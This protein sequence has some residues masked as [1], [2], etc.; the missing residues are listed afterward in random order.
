MLTATLS[1]SDYPF[2]CISCRDLSWVKIYNVDQRYE[3]NRIDGHLQARLVY[4]LMNIHT[5]PRC[6][7][8]CRHG[9]SVC[10]LYGR[11]GGDSDLSDRGRQFSHALKDYMDEQGM[12][13]FKIWTSQLKRTIQTATPLQGTVIQ[14][15]ALNELD[16]GDCEA[17]TYEEIQEKFPREFALRD[18]DKFHYRYPKGESYEDLVH[19]LEPV[20]MELERQ[21]NVLVICHQAVMRCIMAYFLDKTSEELPYIKVP[22]HTIMKLTPVAYGCKV[23][24]VTLP[25]PCVDTYRKQPKRLNSAALETVPGD[26]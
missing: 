25:V 3:A 17:K 14:W 11:I 22:L 15:K 12:K 21:Q 2:A 16:V 26:I 7:Y 10:N 5:Q 18:Q 20:I 8:L 19:R 9:E 23:E 13:G 1:L 4:Y 24:E 6:I